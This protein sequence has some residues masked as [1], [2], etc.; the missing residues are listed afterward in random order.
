MMARLFLS[1]LAGVGLAGCAG[2]LGPSPAS[3]AAEIVQ[4]GCLPSIE[5]TGSVAQ[6]AE[7]AGFTP[8]VSI[9]VPGLPFDGAGAWRRE[10]G[11]S[12]VDVY[13][14]PAGGCAIVAEGASAGSLRAAL[15]QLGSDPRLSLVSMSLGDT[16]Q[17]VI[18]VL[19][20][21]LR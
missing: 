17:S 19:P 4:D 8:S 12:L 13:A 18:L 1:A 20:N 3:L 6:A 21:G 15:P 5:G 2:V 10:V 16:A 11:R 9:A 14:A 7:A